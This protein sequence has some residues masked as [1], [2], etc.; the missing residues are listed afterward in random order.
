MPYADQHMKYSHTRTSASPPPEPIDHV[1]FELD[2]SP[3]MYGRN[4]SKNAGMHSSTPVTKPNHTAG[5]TPNTLNSQTIR[6][7][8]QPRTTGSVSLNPAPEVVQSALEKNSD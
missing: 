3:V 1:M 4:M 2:Q 5:P 6:I 7:R 8:P